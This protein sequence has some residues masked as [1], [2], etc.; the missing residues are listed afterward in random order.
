M[1]TDAGATEGNETKISG[2]IEI[3]IDP[4]PVAVA[5]EMTTA[6]L[7]LHDELAEIKS[8]CDRIAWEAGEARARGDEDAAKI[9]SALQAVEAA[10]QRV[11]ELQAIVTEAHAQSVAARDAC[12]DFRTSS[13][14]ALQTIRDGAASIEGHL[15]LAASAATTTESAAKAGDEALTAIRAAAANAAEAESAAT[16]KRANI[17]GIFAQ[18]Q[19]IETSS[20]TALT[21]MIAA[22]TEA[23]HLV[24]SAKQHLAGI[25]DVV[26]R[27]T[28][29]DARV[30]AYE[31][32]LERLIQQYTELNERIEGLLPGAAS[33]GLASAFEMRMKAFSLPK[34]AW[35]VVFIM[36]IVAL[37]GVAAYGANDALL[38]EKA[39]G[40]TVALYLLRRLPLVAPLVWLAIYAGR[41]HMVAQRLE[42]DYGFKATTSRSFE[43]YKREMAALG[44]DTDGQPLAALCRNVLKILA[45]PPGRVFD[46]KNNDVT[47]AT[48]LADALAQAGI[49]ELKSIHRLAEGNSGSTK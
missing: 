6:A 25:E 49:P 21:Q 39:D 37:I 19:S 11:N 2:P 26:A 24:T 31:H 22:R 15:S 44:H 8:K 45:T 32:D 47:P 41:N 13:E 28:T 33:A 27:V 20:K 23:E 36:C 12:A 30:T 35:A 14:G 10:A 46:A 38:N 40:Q 4:P 3:N 42:E 9:A 29:T 5:A 17:D 16:S 7:R 18:V 48:T 1:S 34:R 43:G